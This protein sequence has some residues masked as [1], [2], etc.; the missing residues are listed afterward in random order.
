MNVAAGGRSYQISTLVVV[1]EMSKARPFERA[2]D[3]VMNDFHDG[4]VTVKSAREVC[5][6]ALD[7]VTFKVAETETAQLCDR[8]APR[9]M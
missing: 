1:V 5:G 4:K 8:C 7:S 2:V 3:E 6:V 9:S